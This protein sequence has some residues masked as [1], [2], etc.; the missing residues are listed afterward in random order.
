MNLFSIFNIFRVQE[1]ISPDELDAGAYEEL[2]KQAPDETTD[3]SV[4]GVPL[5]NDDFWELL[6]RF[7]FSMLVLFI[8]IRLIYYPSTKRKD[9]LFTYLLI[10][11]ITFFICYTLQS[12]KIKLGLAL[13]LFAVFGIIKYRTDAIPIKEMTYLFI[14]I[15]LSVIN[16]LSNNKVTVAELLFTNTA[17]IAIVYGLERVWL[18]QHETS[19]IILYEKIDLIK[20]EKRHLLHKDLEDRTGIKINR[21]SIGKIDFLR[22]T[23]QVIIHYYENNQNISDYSKTSTDDDD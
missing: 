9:Y 5:I 22:D 23:A 20:P 21:I 19:K 15:G 18:L 17:V 2:S 16:A 12:N 13:G 1:D 7:G 11:V 10:S 8:I 4:L 14:V 3:N 6:V